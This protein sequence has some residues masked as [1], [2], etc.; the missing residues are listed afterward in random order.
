MFAVPGPSLR[1]LKLVD[2]RLDVRH[3][4]AGQGRGQGEGEGEGQG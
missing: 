2:N 4:L 3:K 1:V